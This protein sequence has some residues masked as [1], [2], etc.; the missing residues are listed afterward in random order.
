MRFCRYC[1]AILNPDGRCSLC[2]RDNG[3]T[4]EET[5]PGQMLPN[6]TQFSVV[7]ETPTSEPN[8]TAAVE[9]PKRNGI[10]LSEVFYFLSILFGALGFFKLWGFDSYSNMYVGGDA[11]N[12][13]ICACMATAYFV[14]A[15][16]CVL[17]GVSLS[18]YREMKR[19]NNIEMGNAK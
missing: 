8:P 4:P 13:I 15:V 14:L 17:I 7:T 18:I 6:P 2:S 10:T 16:G 9:T 12:Y 5:A 19:Q 11:Y 3:L 1:G